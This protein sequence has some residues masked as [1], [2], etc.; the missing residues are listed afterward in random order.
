[1]SKYLG[2]IAEDAIIYDDFTTT[3]STGDPTTLS[4]T[5]V[6][7]VYKDDNTTQ[8][9]AGITLIVDFDSVT[10]LNNWEIDT[11][12]DA[13]YATGSDY[14]VVI[15]TGTVDGTPVVG[16][17]VATFSIENRFDNGV[18]ALND[19]DP[20]ND[21]V[22]VVTLV[23]TTTASTNAETAIGNLNDIAAPDVTDDMIADARWLGANSPQSMFITTTIVAVSLESGTWTSGTITFTGYSDR[24]GFGSSRGYGSF[25]GTTYT[26]GAGSGN[27]PSIDIQFASMNLGSS[28]VLKITDTAGYEQL[29]Y[30]DEVTAETDDAFIALADGRL[31]LWDSNGLF[32]VSGITI[33]T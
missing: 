16:Y 5:P 21:D 26:P 20:A 8:S 27:S 18:S 28:C 31:A 11:S 24:F 17:V 6:L 1:M 12:A 30:V 2:D 23:N 25:D 13:F 4:G 22:A 29:L 7:S 19:F 32:P 3:D 10:G 15:T 33:P 14:K 9:V